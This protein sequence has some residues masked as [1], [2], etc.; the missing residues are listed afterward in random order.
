MDCLTRQ[1]GFFFTKDAR[2]GTAQ[3]KVC[4]GDVVAVVAALKMPLI[5][6][7]IGSQFCLVGHSYVHGIIDGEAWP[8]GGNSLRTI[9]LL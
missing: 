6:S 5:L 1:G 2:M 9:T 4:L 3:G 8:T 7:P